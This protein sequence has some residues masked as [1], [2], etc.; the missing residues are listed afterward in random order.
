MSQ[1]LGNRVTEHV[2]ARVQAAAP[3][4]R[5]TS[6]S[7]KALHWRCEYRPQRY[8]NSGTCSGN[9]QVQEKGRRDP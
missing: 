5:M 4:S 6:L 1:Q 9:I 2:N 7:A 3:W 8:P